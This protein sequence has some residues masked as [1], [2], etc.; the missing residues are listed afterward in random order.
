MRLGITYNPDYDIYFRMPENM[1][2]PETAYRFVPNSK[3]SYNNILDAQIFLGNRRLIFDG[4]QRYTAEET[5]SLQKFFALVRAEKFN[6]KKLLLL[7]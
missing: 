1:M 4:D 3:L 5:K 7:L 6:S 2:P